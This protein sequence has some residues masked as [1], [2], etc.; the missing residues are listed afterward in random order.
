[1]L[2]SPRFGLLGAIASFWLFA[3]ACGGGEPAGSADATS[4]NDLD[5]TAA[6][7]VKLTSPAGNLPATSDLGMPSQQHKEA[8]KLYPVD[9]APQKPDF[10]AFRQNLLDIVARRDVAALTAVVTPDLRFSF[11][12]ENGRDAF[13]ETWKLNTSASARSELWPLLE[14]VLRGGGTWGMDSKSQENLF[15]APYTFSTYSG[16]DAFAQVAITGEGVRARAKP[17][18]T[19][20]IVT[21]LNYDI[22]TTEYNEQASTTLTD[23]GGRKYAW[24]LVKLADGRKAYVSNKFVASPVGY[25]AFFEQQDGQW[26]MTVF[27]AGD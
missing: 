6:R 3:S 19:S 2:R 21:L 4:V 13:L 23:I 8:G 25:R 12:A 10:V 22:V 18:L 11:G 17:D 14:D 9:E 7:G 5:S 20:T 27:I 1:M 24:T 16:E 15:M 26:R